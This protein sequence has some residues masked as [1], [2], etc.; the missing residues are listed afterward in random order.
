VYAKQLIA[1]A[2]GLL[3]EFLLTLNSSPSR[4]AYGIPLAVGTSTGLCL[5]FFACSPSE[6]TFEPVPFALNVLVSAVP[7]FVVSVRESWGRTLIAAAGPTLA[8]LGLVGVALLVKAPVDLPHGGPVSLLVW[9]A[10]VGVPAAIAAIPPGR[11][12]SDRLKR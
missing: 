10:A 2:G 7:A 3:C 6:T 5:N 12:A 11:R 1:V 4:G 8:Y 9:A